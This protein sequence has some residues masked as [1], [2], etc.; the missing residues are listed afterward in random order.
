[1]EQ[2]TRLASCSGLLLP[3]PS[4]PQSWI[5]L[6]LSNFIC[7]SSISCEMA[8]S[9]S[10][11]SEPCFALPSRPTAKARATPLT[12]VGESVSISQNLF[13]KKRPPPGGE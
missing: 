8:S 13:R 2:E 4:T 5:D 11:R 10:G 6:K 12:Q 1:M 3:L 7:N 9:S